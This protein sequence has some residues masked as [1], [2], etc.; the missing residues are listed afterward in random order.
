MDDGGG[1]GGVTVNDGRTDIA[2][3]DGGCTIAPR[4]GGSSFIFNLL[5]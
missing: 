5:N 3:V 4:I 1:G 2:V